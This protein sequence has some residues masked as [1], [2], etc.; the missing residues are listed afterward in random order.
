MS[1]ENLNNEARIG[2]SLL[3][4]GLGV[5]H[6]FPEDWILK[7]NK[8][9]TLERQGCVFSGQE[10]LDNHELDIGKVCYCGRPNK[11]PNIE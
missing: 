5:A 1:N 4:A 9:K 11:T 10:L 2:L 8:Q 7:S 6:S 3:N